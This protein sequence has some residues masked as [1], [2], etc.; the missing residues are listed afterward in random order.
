MENFLHS[1][2][3]AFVERPNGAPN[4]RPLRHLNWF[5][6]REQ[7]QRS[8]CDRRELLFAHKASG[9]TCARES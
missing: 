5:C 3:K 7:F 9:P 8:A 2:L 1:R 4:R 6:W